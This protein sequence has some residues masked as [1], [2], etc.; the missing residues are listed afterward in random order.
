MRR[1]AVRPSS[2]SLEAIGCS[3]P[4]PSTVIRSPGAPASTRASLTAVARASD[5]FLFSSGSPTLSLCP[6]IFSLALPKAFRTFAISMVAVD[7]S[8]S[9]LPVASSNRRSSATTLFDEP[10]PALSVKEVTSFSTYE[11]AGTS[12]LRLPGSEM[13]T[14]FLVV[15]TRALPSVVRVLPVFATFWEIRSVFLTEVSLTGRVSCAGL[16]SPLHLTLRTEEIEQS[17]QNKGE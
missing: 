8:E 2:V 11:F 14:S 4:A 15:S 5:F 13:E 7:D 17:P 3:R 16:F 12:I 10:A 9:S 6:T 1:L